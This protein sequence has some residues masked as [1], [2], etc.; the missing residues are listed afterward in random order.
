[1]STALTSLKTGRATLA[2]DLL[3]GLI[4]AVAA[5]PDGL[6]SGVLA[7]RRESGLWPVQ[8][9]DRHSGGGLVHQLCLYGRDQYQRYGFGRI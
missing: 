2:R 3:A 8:P 5:I 7:G 6:A 9:D 1:M 4:A